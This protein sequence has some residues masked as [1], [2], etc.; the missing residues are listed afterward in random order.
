MTRDII[1]GHLLDESFEV[2]LG[3]LC[4]ACA[5]DTVWVSALVAEGVLEP[6]DVSEAQWRFPAVSLQRAYRAM[7]LERDL[8]VNL[9][10]IAL[11]IEL[12]EEL[13]ALRARLSRLDDD[14]DLNI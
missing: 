11:A 6:I 2:S 5:R 3:E 12:L 9:A 1:S 14:G 10:G 4:N 7:R 8:G 13:Q